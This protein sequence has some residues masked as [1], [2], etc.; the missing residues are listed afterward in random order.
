MTTFP[1]PFTPDLTTRAG[2]MMATGRVKVTATLEDR[3]HVTILFKAFADNRDRDFDDT[4]R[5]NWVPC[6]LE[7]ASHVFV[8]VPNASGEWNDKVGTF[9]PRTGRWYSADNADTM[10]VDTAVSIAQWLITP[11]IDRLK[12]A[13]PEIVEFAESTECAV[14]GLELSDPVSIQRGIG[15]T[16]FGNMTGSHH[17][18]KGL[19]K[20]KTDPKQTQENSTLSGALTE[21][22]TAG[23]MRLEAS[24]INLKDDNLADVAEVEL[25]IDLRKLST[26]WLIVLE[27][28]CKEER[29]VRAARDVREMSRPAADTAFLGR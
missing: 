13:L 12:L 29:A 28:A 17:Q 26:E 3:S 15:P 25:G 6:S 22:P 18:V 16:C 4:V 7:K 21:A 5:K 19:L 23:Q 8:E 2:R 20:P 27:N 9:Y 24:E 10:R 14:C 1:H 11:R